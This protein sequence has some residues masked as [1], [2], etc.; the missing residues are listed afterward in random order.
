MYDNHCHC[1]RVGYHWVM[2]A[3]SCLDIPSADMDL[4]ITTPSPPS[5]PPACTLNPVL[6]IN[7]SPFTFAGILVGS[8]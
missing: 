2:A 4:S 3:E 6:T 8:A 7:P 1:C 5:S